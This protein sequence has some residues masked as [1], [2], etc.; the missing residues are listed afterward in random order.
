MSGVGFAV[1]R[2]GVSSRRYGPSNPHSHMWSPSLDDH[3]GSTN[4][5]GSAGIAVLQSLPQVLRRSVVACF[6][7]GPQCTG[8]DASSLNRRLL[9]RLH[10]D[11]DRMACSA[12]FEL[13]MKSEGWHRVA[14]CELPCSRSF[15]SG[16]R[17]PTL[18]EPHRC[19]GGQ[20]PC[21]F[22]WLLTMR[23]AFGISTLVTGDL[24]ALSIEHRHFNI[25]PSR[26]QESAGALMWVWVT[27]AYLVP[28]Q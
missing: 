13:G 8:L 3:S 17:C 22:S 2:G 15:Y 19:R 24:P 4:P 7:D 25:F 14:A 6:C 28:Q 1:G 12:L 20:F 23:C 27:F 21:I 5:V 9:A 11:R 18:A 16:A 26:R 10:G